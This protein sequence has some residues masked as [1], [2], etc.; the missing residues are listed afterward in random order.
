MKNTLLRTFCLL[1]MVSEVS[2][3][4][5]FE[6]NIPDIGQRPSVILG[7][8]EERMIG[9]TLM[10]QLNG[11][12]E[13]ID[14]PVIDEYLSYLSQKVTSGAPHTDFKLHFFGIKSSAVNA[15]AF[16]GGHIAVH[17]G[18]ILAV[19]S[20][21]ELAAVLAHETAHITQHHLAR[22]L[23]NNK[24][25]MPLTYAEILGALVIGALGSPE[26]AGHLV[27][28][29]LGSHV[30]RLINFT[31]EH[32]QEADRI[33]I[34]ILSKAGFDPHALGEVFRTLHLSTRFQEKP[35]EYLLT[36]PTFESRIADAENRAAKLP[37]PPK[38]DTTFFNL[39][40]A[41]S[42]ARLPE[43]AK[44]KVI[45][46]GDILA[47]GKHDRISSEYAYALAL[48]GNR[49]YQEAEYILS[50]L[51]SA[52]PNQWIIRLGLAETL[53]AKG[54]TVQALEQMQALYERY[55]QNHA[56]NLI[57]AEMLLKAKNAELAKQILLAHTSPHE[58]PRQHQLLAR[59]YG[60]LGNR[61]ELHLFQANWHYSRGEFQPALQQLGLGLEY[62]KNNPQLATKLKQRREKM[63]SLIKQQKRAKL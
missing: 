33:G 18:L 13:R 59:I 35:P 21:G 2:Y 39:T 6:T 11:S 50:N 54:D 40:R 14:D 49:K 63:L 60:K 47:R 44:N 23:T 55:P 62:T 27:T 56:I 31:R 30:Q 9:E 20:E 53:E 61:A 10:Q 48:A 26:A 41:R 45:R 52:Q 58:D 28:A 7:I 19:R 17:S 12:D 57:Y 38:Q 36:H 37:Q 16:F 29:A 32:E 1:I 24:K 3:A 34:Q 46:L 43:N 42:D 5:V 15:F 22:I 51:L 25:M 8:Q 4:T